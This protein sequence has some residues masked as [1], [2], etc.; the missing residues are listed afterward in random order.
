MVYWIFNY[1]SVGIG[2]TPDMMWVSNINIF[3]PGIGFIMLTLGFLLFLMIGVYLE[4][5]VPSE[6]GKQLHPCFPFMPRS[7]TCCKKKRGQAVGDDD[8]DGDQQAEAL[9]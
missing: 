2:F 7:Y 6:F 1:E 8:E 3:C 4:Y 9:L 5:V